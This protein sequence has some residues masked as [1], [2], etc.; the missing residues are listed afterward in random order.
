MRTRGWDLSFVIFCL[1][2]G[3]LTRLT[4]FDFDAANVTRVA[5]GTCTASRVWPGPLIAWR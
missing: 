5:S 2:L 3:F 1:D 4:G